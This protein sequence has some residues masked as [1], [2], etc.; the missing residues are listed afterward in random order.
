MEEREWL[1]LRLRRAGFFAFSAVELLLLGLLLE[2]NAPF[3]QLAQEFRST[4]E[5]NQRLEVD[6]TITSSTARGFHE[7]ALLLDQARSRFRGAGWSSVVR[8]TAERRNGCSRI[9]PAQ[10]GAAQ[11]FHIFA[12][13]LPGLYPEFPLRDLLGCPIRETRCFQTHR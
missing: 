7:P 10:F 13:F 12:G 6:A 9:K 8:G 11:L 1:W 2:F 3:L 4:F 5:F